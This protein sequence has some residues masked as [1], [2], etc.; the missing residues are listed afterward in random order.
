[1]RRRHP[2]LLPFALLL[3]GPAPLPGQQAPA[4]P[5]HATIDARLDELEA[6]YRHLHQHP[7]LSF[8]EKQT[9]ARFADELQKLGLEV[10]R[11]V[12][13]HGVVGVR[14]NGAGPVLLLRADLDALPIAEQT[15]L[16]Y[17]APHLGTSAEG[18]P[19]GIMHACG[20]DLHMTSLIGSVAVLLAHP[21]RWRGTIVAIGQ[22][23][24]ERAGGARAMLRD[25][26]FERFPKPDFGIALHCS[27]TG[28]TGMVGVRPGY[29][30]AN[31]DSVDVTL[32]GRG[33][34]G[35][36]PHQTVDPIVQAAALVLE[37]QTIVSREVDPIEP[38]VV[39][40]GAIH[41][42]SKHNII[43]DQCSLQITLRSYAPAVREQLKAAVQRK[44]RAVAAAHRAPEPRIEF[45]EP[46]AA[47]HNDP[48]LT[49]RVIA[50]LRAELGAE[51]VADEPPT[52]GAEDFAEFGR[53]GVPICMFR[54][55]TIAPERL[56]KMRE[57]GAVPSLHS[58]RYHP[59]VRESLRTGIRATVAVAL[60]LLR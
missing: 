1:M 8:Q 26:L 35:S 24:E 44:A 32:F 25:G 23:A 51:N 46:A 22:P 13:G 2:A 6:L 50:A 34:H 11:S 38:A 45:S 12:G 56:Q 9:A 3:A 4:A 41:G 20:H 33:G 28:P 48:R 49:E 7:E 59:D 47:L 53:A 43:S 19:V 36:A 14:K 29:A 58:D 57:N 15:G 5:F 30:M 54:L 37:L 40:V 55:G 42:G 21:D 16:P 60:D 52:M 17:A 39:T 27:A 10:T 18:R 31:V